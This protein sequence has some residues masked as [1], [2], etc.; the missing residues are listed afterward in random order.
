MGNLIE[1]CKGQHQNEMA[2]KLLHM[3]C[4]VFYVA[5]QLYLLPALSAEGML[6]PWMHFFKE[7]L[8]QPLPDHL[9]SFVEDMD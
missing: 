8:D 9:S 7:I 1:A 3:I 2:L 5:N 4:K 6:H